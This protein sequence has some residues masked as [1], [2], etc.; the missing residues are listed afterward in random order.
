MVL[1]GA[2]QPLTLQP[3]LRIPRPRIKARRFIKRF[4]GPPLE[5]GK[6]EKKKAAGLTAAFK[7]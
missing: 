1:S 3:A 6:K 4:I 5:E 7:G 2:V